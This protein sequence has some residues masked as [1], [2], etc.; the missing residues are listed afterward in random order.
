MYFLA[1]CALLLR[2]YSQIKKCLEQSQRDGGG[3]VDSVGDRPYPG[4]AIIQMY[5][6]WKQITVENSFS[7]SFRDFKH[8]KIAVRKLLQVLHYSCSLILLGEVENNVICL[9]TAI[10]IEIMNPTTFK[11][12]IKFRVYKN[13]KNGHVLKHFTWLVSCTHI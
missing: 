12:Q 6:S 1:P 10:K 11:V 8:N 7:N 9:P 4:I 5:I 2:R 3:D 13:S